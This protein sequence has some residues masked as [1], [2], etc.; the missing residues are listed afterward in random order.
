[1]AKVK[2]QVYDG[3]EETY[4]DKGGAIHFFGE[5]FR[6]IMPDAYPFFSLNP[7]G[8]ARKSSRGYRRSQQGRGSEKQAPWRECFKQCADRWNAMPEECPPFPPCPA[9]SSK[10]SVWEAKQD[11]G[12]MCS[13]YDLFMD[14]CLTSCTEITIYGPDGIAYKGGVISADN[15]CW[16]C[17]PPCLVDGL[18]IDYTAPCMPCGAQQT[19]YAMDSVYD[20]FIPCCG[21]EEIRWKIIQGGGHLTN[22]T[23]LQTTYQAP[24]CPQACILPVVIEVSDCCNRSATLTLTIT[25]TTAD[26]DAYY[27]DRGECEITCEA[28]ELYGTCG[29]WARYWR[30]FYTCAGVLR[31]SEIAWSMEQGTVLGDC[32]PTSLCYISPH[33]WCETELHPYQVVD[34]RTEEQIEAGCC[35][36]IFN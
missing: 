13:F 16:P 33:N 22:E 25:D 23:G 4:T 7:T 14:C 27:I 6:H 36:P 19:L 1:M 29:S 11:Q 9:V 30:D 3:S 31:H 35:P 2:N 32:S 5:L 17:V 18:S 15:Q 20:N 8:I 12:V 10:K 24:A 28:S 34:L 26:Y 21:E